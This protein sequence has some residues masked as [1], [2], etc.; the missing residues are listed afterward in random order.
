MRASI[1]LAG[2]L[3][4][5]AMILASPI[6]LFGADQAAVTLAH[7]SKVENNAI[8]SREP[9]D[10]A[11]LFA[12]FKGA[13]SAAASSKHRT[14]NTEIVVDPLMLSEHTG[15]VVDMPATEIF[16]RGKA[17][18]PFRLVNLEYH[19]MVRD[20]IRERDVDKN[21]KDAVAKSADVLFVRTKENI[22][23][24]DVT[25]FVRSEDNTS[26]NNT[27][28]DVQPSTDT[29]RFGVA[30]F[31]RKQDMVNVSSS[32]SFVRAED[33][34][35]KTHRLFVRNNDTEDEVSE[36]TE[37]DFK[38]H[39]GPVLF[40]RIDNAS[41]LKNATLFVR[42]GAKTSNSNALF[43]RA[44]ENFN[45]ALDQVKVTLFV[46]SE[47]AA[48]VKFKALFVRV[49]EKVNT[50]LFVRGEDPSDSENNTLFVR[51]EEVGEAEDSVLFVRSELFDET[52]VNVLFV[53]GEDVSET[54]GSELFVRRH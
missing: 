26:I 38:E 23:N 45:A 43:V 39:N 27:T 22:Q 19:P 41:V 34:V 29:D 11:K 33:A 10:N 35:D 2:V 5:V 53:R 42:G 25:L 9:K 3:A 12:G 31:V 6:N 47:A 50:T 20:E 30:L 40:V 7:T 32:P 46:R 52:E 17:L 15:H 48:G 28:V 36:V 18:V 24:Q 13:S 51:N 14:G 8:N 16:A 4:L 54:E 49:D 21:N 1:F 37:P 44:A